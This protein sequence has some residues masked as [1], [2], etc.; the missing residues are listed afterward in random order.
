ML[1]H[2]HNVII[3]NYL[4]IRYKTDV[5]DVWWHFIHTRWQKIYTLYFLLRYQLII[6]IEFIWRIL[7]NWL[8]LKD[9]HWAVA[10]TRKK[11]KQLEICYSL[12]IKSSFMF[13]VPSIQMN[14]IFSINH[15]CLPFSFCFL[16]IY[17][18]YSCKNDTL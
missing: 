12:Y 5:L 9:I 7:K 2:C 1:W 6:Q 4:E 11:K 10:I 8:F 16:M 17:F 3:R 15:Y 13:F 18:Y 14:N